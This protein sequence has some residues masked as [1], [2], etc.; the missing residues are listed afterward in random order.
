MAV[1]SHPDVAV[2]SRPDVAV[3]IHPDVAVR[4]HP[5]VA[6]H[7]H[8]DVAVHSR[9]DVAGSRPDA[10]DNLHPVLRYCYTW[11]D[12]RLFSDVADSLRCA[13]SHAAAHNHPD[14]A[15]R[16]VADMGA[17]VAVLQHLA[18]QL[19]SPLV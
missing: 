16:D 17:A 18:E 8:P 10:T 15:G 6:V 14:A 11:A 4:I 3:R 13:D 9:P 5:D 19:R 2:H 12:S 7:I 1:H